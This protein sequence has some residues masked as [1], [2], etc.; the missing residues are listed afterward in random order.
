MNPKRQQIK[1]HAARLFRQQG[2]RATNMR[3][4]ARA[5]GIKA[6]SLYNHIANKEELLQE[7]I[8]DMA[9]LFTT[10]ME[11]AMQSPL[12]PVEKLHRLIADY[13]RYTIDHTDAISLLTS[14]WIHLADEPRSQFL[15][16]RDN[17]EDG[18]RQILTECM[19]AGYFKNLDVDIALYSTLST[20]RWLYSWYSK[21]NDTDPGHLREQ[22][23]QILINGIRN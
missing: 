20:L 22:L 14:E 3:Q 1:A 21:H 13:V 4:L 18:F 15:R 10:S 7:L 2:Y 8:M 12:N 5:V 19:E 11:E 23:T 9:L 6:A 17:Y 16:L